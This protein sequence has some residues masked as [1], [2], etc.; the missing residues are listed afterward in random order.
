VSALGD[1]ARDAG[2]EPRQRGEGVTEVGA[3]VVDADADSDDPSEAVVVN[4]P[5]V[6]CSDWHAYGDTTVADDN[7][8][9]DADAHVVVVAFRDELEAAYPEWEADSVLSLPLECPAYGF[10]P[11]RLRRVGELAGEER[12]GSGAGPEREGNTPADTPSAAD[13][14]E[15]TLRDDLDAIA[16]AVEELNVD[17]VAV[18][19][20]REA[21]VVDKLGVEYLISRDGTVDDD[22]RVAGALEEA[23]EEVVDE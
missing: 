2:T 12:H 17:S 8:E 15:A 11:R 1:D 14:G 4:R 23:A 3:I 6:S 13:D 18:D 20:F 21:V 7:P 16:S 10:P 5:P 22:D 9:Y 19:T